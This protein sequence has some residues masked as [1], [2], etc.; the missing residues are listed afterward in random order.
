MLPPFLISKVARS[1]RSLRQGP[2]TSDDGGHPTSSVRELRLLVMDTLRHSSP[3]EL[4]SLF[5]CG[6]VVSSPPNLS[7][8]GQSHFLRDAELR[9]A[10]ASEFPSSVRDFS[11]D[12]ESEK[13]WRMLAGIEGRRSRPRPPVWIFP[14]RRPFGALGREAASQLQQASGPGAEC[15]VDL[16]RGPRGRLRGRGSQLPDAVE[17]SC[18]SR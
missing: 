15:K 6:L 10:S 7:L 11:C 18:R 9:N 3:V 5:A 12:S 4:G 13:M 14:H 8:A 16:Q 2:L 17:G 1:I